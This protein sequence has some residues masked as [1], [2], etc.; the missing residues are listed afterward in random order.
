MDDLLI[1]ARTLH[2][3]SVIALSGVFA[4]E[5]FVVSPAL[6]QSGAA[7]IAAGLRR[8]FRWLTWG[9]LVLAIGSGAAWLVAVAARMSGKPLA[10][11]LSSGV[12]TLV[13][14]R[15]QF[16][17]IWLLRLALAVLLG[18][19]FVAR[20]RRRGW[21]SGAIEWAGLA[22]SSLLVA[23]LAWAGHG[24]ATPGEPGDLH[25][26]AD[27]FHLLA[28]SVWLG[29]L[30]PLALL[31]A[32]ARRMHDPTWAAIARA[33]TR[34]FSVLAMASV[35]A[36]F[37]AGLVNTWFL[38]GTIPALIGTEYGRLLL[39]KIAI[40]IAMVVIAAVNLLRLTPR[41]AASSGRTE[42]RVWATVAQ[43]R[44]NAVVEA[45]CG[46]AILTIVGALGILPPGLHTEPGWPLP[47][48]FELGALTLRADIILAVLAA[49][50]CVC[51]VAIVTAAAAGRYRRIAVPLVGLVL[52]LSI[53]WVPLRP[54]VERAYPTTYYAPAEP[55]AVPSIARGMALYAE[56][57]A[58]CHGA[59]GRG[60]GPA[61]AS[62][63]TRPADL[64][65][66]HLFT[67]EEGDLFWWVSHGSDDGVMP[68]FAGVLSTPQLW[69][70][71]SFI[72]ARA[73]GTLV[74]ELGPEVTTDATFPV[75]DF[76]F[77]KDGRSQTL[78]DELKRGPVLLVL[79]T[80]PTP[81]ARLAQLA[82][83]R[84]RFAAA[85]LEA[86][87]V[88]VSASSPRPAAGEEPPLVVAVSAE[89]ASTLALFANGDHESEL[90]LDRAG[91]MRARWTYE[92]GRGLPEADTLVAAADRVVRFGITI[93]SHAG[94]AH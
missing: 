27:V 93:W 81:I 73:A 61:A 69:D 67:H 41:L 91:N 8:R 25:L 35:A 74:H 29:T 58:L 19:C 65:G 11:A 39:A 42:G 68:G 70:V 53:G 62:L 48:R 10:D 3:A 52:C 34:R 59:T 54:A 38:A 12:V 20:H 79:F 24:A 32:E 82:A 23:T 40:F 13:L 50:F 31:L 83:A 45:S 1:A 43:L 84:P 57:C 88:D 75:P 16:G 55:Y 36:L 26:A 44:R 80:P 51:S 86:L 64:T 85:G 60:N 46:L 76:A 77:E 15:T 78:E 14:T 6:H 63:P 66:S 72:R 7:E 89:V 87:A 92:N 17:Q 49:L 28:A 30:L 4:F 18:I 90:M 9:S 47:F 5:C 56:N 33:A 37:S 22:L 94:H 2:F 71:I 21:T